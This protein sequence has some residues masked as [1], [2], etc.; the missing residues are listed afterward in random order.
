M[1]TVT[2]IVQNRP[3][4]EAISLPSKSRERTEDLYIQQDILMKMTSLKFA[5]IPDLSLLVENR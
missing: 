5:F 1:F 3:S 2:K 4:C